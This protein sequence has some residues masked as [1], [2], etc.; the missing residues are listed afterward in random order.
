M[1]KSGGE[2]CLGLSSAILDV[3]GTEEVTESNDK[4]EEEVVVE[5]L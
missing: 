2:W 3:S 1:L 4:L 5:V